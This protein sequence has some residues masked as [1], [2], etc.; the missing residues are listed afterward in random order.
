M[1]IAYDSGEDTAL[2][3]NLLATE[4][5]TNVSSV[6]APLQLLGPINVEN[7]TNT[8]VPAYNG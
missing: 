1:Q 3:A 4:L 7:V 6:L 2:A 5:M 8:E